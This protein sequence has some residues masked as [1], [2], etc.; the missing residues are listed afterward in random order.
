MVSGSLRALALLLVSSLTFLATAT[1]ATATHRQEDRPPETVKGKSE[2]IY[3][4]FVQEEYRVKT[5]HGRIFGVVR[6]PVVPEGVKVPVIL[7]YSP[8]NIT[9]QPDSRSEL[10]D[11][12]TTYFNPRGYARAVFDLVGTRES[13][14]CYDY[15]GKR[16][17][18]TAADVVD[19]LGTRK[20]SNGKVGMI[21][22]SYDGTTAWAAAVEAPKHLTTIVPQVAIG[23]WWDYAFGQG[24][25]FA[26][27]SATPYG[28]DYG[29]GMV[30][31]VNPSDPEAW[32]EAARDHMTPCERVQHNE[33]AFLPDPVYDKFWDERDYLKRID[34]VKASVMIEGSW[35]DYNVHPINSIE[36]WSALPDGHPSRLLMSTQ[37]HAGVNFSDA[38]AIRHAW[39]DQWLL[40]L[41][42]GIMEL[43]RSDSQ[44]APGT[45]FQDAD[46]PPPG[47]RLTNLELGARGADLALQGAEA[48]VWTDNNPAL[49][50]RGVMDGRG[51]GA[52]VLFL[53]EPVKGDT[54]IAGIPV[55]KA[56]VVTDAVSTFLTPVLFDEAPGGNRS[57][58]TKGLLNARNRAG[59]R[60]SIPLTP[61]EVWRAV[62][63]FQPID[64]ELKPGHRLGLAVMSMN[65][66][67]ALYPD[68]VRATNEILLNGE[69]RLVLPL[70][71]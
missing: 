36:M 59:L 18:E 69:S 58:I 31:P 68:D 53:D 2:P 9:T 64:W 15:G 23:R 32:A 57:V 11:D 4:D 51:F 67:E 1:I 54:R 70:A 49:A 7:T 33:K 30:P 62:V 71:P 63:R 52:A 42:T 12:I 47:T 46:W 21:G 40:G 65:T 66:A 48:A 43:P 27:G 41:N 10:T 14:G 6:R 29:F 38:V 60:K 26:S 39:F 44:V 20:W 28:F 37:G 61:G 55:L 17:R 56:D 45:R 25:R 19:Y 5:D 50:E 8:Y 16:E 13:S 22:G 24:V 34:K 35:S 3:D